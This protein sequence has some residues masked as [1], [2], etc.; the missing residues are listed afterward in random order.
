MS[1]MLACITCGRQYPRDEVR[2]RC[3]CGETLEVAYTPGD[4]TRQTGTPA[5]F[6]ARLA[7]R[8]GSFAS[9]VWRFREWLPDFA[10]GEIVSKPEG[11]TN[12]YAVGAGESGGPGRIG[13]YAG[14][15]R[16][17]LKHEGENPTGSFK[18][19]GM[20][21]GVSQARRLGARA[22]ACASTGNTSASL[23]AYAAQADI[24]CFVFIP[25]GKI[26][27]GKLAQSLG[28]GAVTVQI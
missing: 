2:Y 7:L 4:P 13:A 16:L 3:D 21:L 22:V 6:D 27:V 25:A 18:D 23:A 28:Y 9:G 24:P 1:A 8:Q 20:T 15:E 11:N 17:T 14:V 19:R 12:L 5:R 10:E 26:A